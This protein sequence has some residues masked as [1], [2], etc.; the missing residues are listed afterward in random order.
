M[1]C[2]V[3]LPQDYMLH[4]LRP[5]VDVKLRQRKIIKKTNLKESSINI[6]IQRK[7]TTSGEIDVLFAKHNSRKSPVH[8]LLEKLQHLQNSN[9]SRVWIFANDFNATQADEGFVGRCEV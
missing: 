1:S 6:C 3:T 5:F 8:A 4:L 2:F 9:M 7:H